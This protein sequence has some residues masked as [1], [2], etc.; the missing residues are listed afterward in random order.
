MS[1]RYASTKLIHHHHH[2]RLTIVRP[3][4]ILRRRRRRRQSLLNHSPHI[5][6]PALPTPADNAT[7]YREYGRIIPIASKLQDILGAL[8]QNKYKSRLTPNSRHWRSIVGQVERPRECR[9]R[10]FLPRGTGIVTHRPLVLQ[11]YDR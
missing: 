3:T 10:S 5:I 7:I 4:T 11:Y 8:G 2:R 9:G 6:N 1:K